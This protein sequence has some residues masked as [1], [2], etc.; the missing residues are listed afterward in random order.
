[1]TAVVVTV[2]AKASNGTPPFTFTWDFRDGP[3]PATGGGRLR[4]KRAGIQPASPSDVT[5]VAA[6]RR[7][8]SSATQGAVLGVGTGRP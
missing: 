5:S 7:T 4:P 1:M 6:R 8:V 3:P 2:E